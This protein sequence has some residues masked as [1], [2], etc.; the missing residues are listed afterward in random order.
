[1]K[2]WVIIYKVAEFPDIRSHIDTVRAVTPML[3]WSVIVGNLAECNH[4]A[5]E[6]LLCLPYEEWAEKSNHGEFDLVHESLTSK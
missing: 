6:L 1:M 5:Q 3:A 2:E 4:T